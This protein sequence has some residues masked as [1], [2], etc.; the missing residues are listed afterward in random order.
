MISQ[1]IAALQRAGLDMTAEE[2]ADMLWLA[3]QID[4]TP[5]T[6]SQEL[7]TDIVENVDEQSL[8]GKQPPQEIAQSFSNPDHAA[9]IHTDSP[10]T[11]SPISQ[12]DTVAQ[13]AG[14][15]FRSPAAS[16]L[17]NTLLLSRA[18]RPFMRR[19]ASKTTFVFNEPTTV[20]RI[21]EVHNNV[22]IPVLKPAPARWFDIALVIDEGASMTLWKQTLLEW[23]MLLTSS[24]SNRCAEAA[25]ISSS[26]P[27]FMRAR[28]SPAS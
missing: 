28:A 26:N 6:A 18:L 24:S 21:A 22:W 14:F 8:V 16:A 27:S 17:P 20:Q 2:I 13:S 19:I 1:F 7:P 11:D 10:H 9:T 15:P 25:S 3:L 23:R 12:D 5:E 4:A